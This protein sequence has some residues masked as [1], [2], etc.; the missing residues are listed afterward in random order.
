MVVRKFNSAFIGNRIPSEF[1]KG[2]R[3]SEFNVGIVISAFNEEKNIGQ[4]LSRLNKIGY[5]EAQ[6][7]KSA[8]MELFT[9][10]IG[11]PS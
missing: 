11:R 7:A 6:R 10:K 2:V 3:P 5:K 8:K 1:L 4:V 9:D